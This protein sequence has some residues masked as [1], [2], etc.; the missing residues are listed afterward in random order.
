MNVYWNLAK[1]NV[2]AQG[3]KVNAFVYV[4]KKEGSIVPPR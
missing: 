1:K 2:S 3:K 4:K